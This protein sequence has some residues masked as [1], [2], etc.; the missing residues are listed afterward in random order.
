LFLQVV[1]DSQVSQSSLSHAIIQG[2]QIL[3]DIIGFAIATASQI[4]ALPWQRTLS[5]PGQS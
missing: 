4:L 1:L 3:L 2:C 5:K